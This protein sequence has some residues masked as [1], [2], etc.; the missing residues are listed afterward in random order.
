MTSK[1]WIVAGAIAIG[2]VMFIRGG[3]LNQTTKAPDARLAS[4]FDDMCKIAR[5]GA[6]DPVRG[7][8][9]LG[10]YYVKH[11]GDI[12]GDFGAT[13]AAIERIADD[14]KHDARARLARDRWRA[15]SCPEDWER[16]AAA[17]EGSP[18]AQEMIQHVSDR[19]GRT[20]EIILSGAGLP[21]LSGLNLELP[22]GG[23]ATKPRAAA[24]THVPK[25]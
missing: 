19:L 17:I 21:T 11:A 5:D 3:C 24:G 8:R 12:L 18:D 1:G 2:G 20:F 14:E 9:K 6:K 16:F 25:P 4:R 22:A 23:F 13:I 15:V 10:V 7:V